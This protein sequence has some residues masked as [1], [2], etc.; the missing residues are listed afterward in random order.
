MSGGGCHR[1]NGPEKEE[2]AEWGFDGNIPANSP[3][4]H[5]VSIVSVDTA[6]VSEYRGGERTLSFSG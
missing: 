4:Y 3:I 6:E 5:D 1:G 2:G